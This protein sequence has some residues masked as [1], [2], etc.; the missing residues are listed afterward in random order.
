M[1]GRN[2]T[3]DRLEQAVRGIW[4]APPHG[5]GR[6]LVLA[7]SGGRDSM[8]LLHAAVR[9]GVPRDGAVVAT[10]D[11]GTG[12]AATRAAQLV[13]REAAA[14]GLPVVIGRAASPGTTEAEWRAARRGFLGDVARRVGG[15]AVTAHTRDDQVE[16]VLMRVMREAGAR[17][18]AGLYAGTDALRPLL[19]F[20]RAEVAEYAAAVGA[21]WIDD[22]TNDSMRFLRNRVRHDLLPAL[23]RVAP[24]LDERLLHLSRAASGWRERVDDVTSRIARID[25]DNA[26]VAIDA[27]ALEHRSAEELAVLWPACAAR[28]GLAMD[29][30]GT[31]RAAAFTKEGHPGARIPLSGGWEIARK[32]RTFELRRTQ[33]RAPVPSPRP[34][35]P[36]MQWEDW[37]FVATP[38]AP[39]VSDGWMAWLPDGVALTVRGWRPG[40]R[41][42]DSKGGLRKVK[43]FLS[44]AHVSGA[45]R[46]RWPVVLAGDEIVW[47]PGIRRSSAAAA[48]S[49][50]PATCYRCELDDR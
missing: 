9:A 5:S 17:G 21:R 3:T 43:R 36:G 33:E 32:H 13:A 40:D 34:L 19:A 46:E 1:R 38:D 23:S 16:T 35:L 48:R 44:D 31:Q 12:S 28:V 20:S 10:F 11:H 2:G 26:H 4:H 45:R 6:S 39:A 42:R 50:G 25:A 37:R 18:L 24:D 15:V 41:M 8:A 29:W 47:I 49:G 22:P 14:L 7:V 30:R 27:A